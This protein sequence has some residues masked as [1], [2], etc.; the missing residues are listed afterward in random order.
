MTSG[1]ETAEDHHKADP[2]GTKCELGQRGKAIHSL[3]MPNQQ[4]A[5]QL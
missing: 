2:G 4:G 3:Y 5:V 1:E